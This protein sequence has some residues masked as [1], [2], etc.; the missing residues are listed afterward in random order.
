MRLGF[1][2]MILVLIFIVSLV[3]SCNKEKVDICFELN[4]LMIGNSLTDE[5]FAYFPFIMKELVPDGTSINVGALYISGC[6]TSKHYDNLINGSKEYRYHCFELDQG[7]WITKNDYSSLDALKERNWHYIITNTFTR[8][9]SY[10]DCV[11]P[12]LEL[13]IEECSKYVSD[14]TK[15]L[16]L[17]TPSLADCYENKI[18]A[19]SSNEF[20]LKDCEVCKQLAL[21]P[22]LWG[23]IP[24]GTAI[25]HARQ[26]NLNCLGNEGELTY[27]KL[28][29]QEG[30]PK[31]LDSYVVCQFFLEKVFSQG[32]ISHSSFVPSDSFL[33][34]G[35]S[36]GNKGVSVGVTV[37]N[38][39]L[40]K[41]IAISAVKHPFDNSFIAE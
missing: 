12:Y 26:T 10:Y 30:I 40:C 38:I 16:W 7:R 13:M 23:I 34:S 15:F 36:L 41:Q 18:N 31:L 20:Y 24:C 11:Q 2:R 5:A 27:D 25:Q 9:P 4:I 22:G 35:V 28:H 14:S 17:Q 33:L 3:S 19:T 39:N 1:L 8:D 6:S 32:S 37:D 29:L 21:S